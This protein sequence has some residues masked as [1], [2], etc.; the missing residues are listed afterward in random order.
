MSKLEEILRFSTEP[1]QVS[2]Y[3]GLFSGKLMKGESI[4]RIEI[5]VNLT[6][7]A[8]IITNKRIVECKSKS[9]GTELDILFYVFWD[10]LMG[11]RVLRGVLS[12][13]FEFSIGN[14]SAVFKCEGYN[15]S[16]SMD[17][18]RYILS[19]IASRANGGIETNETTENEASQNKNVTNTSLIE[20]KLEK[21]KS[22]FD[23]GLISEQEYNE[24]KKTVLLEI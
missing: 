11:A 23:K 12:D 20:T 21:L 3:Y 2:K 13:D 1:K 19:E 15:T 10:S 22:L 9:F 6:P 8:L 7:K 16:T 14:S 24:M 18:I 17:A 5:E 4:E